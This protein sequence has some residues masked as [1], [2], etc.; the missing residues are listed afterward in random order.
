LGTLKQR[1]KEKDDQENF[2]NTIL[3]MGKRLASSVWHYVL[4]HKKMEKESTAPEFWM[5]SI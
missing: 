4:N 2:G 5:K 3:E 1:K